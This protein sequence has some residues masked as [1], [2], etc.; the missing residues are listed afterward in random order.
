MSSKNIYIQT[1]IEQLE[2][3][4]KN[5][6]Y[7]LFSAKSSKINPALNGNL[8]HHKEFVEFINQSINFTEPFVSFQEKIRYY[9]LDKK[10]QH[11]CI[12]C[13]S[14]IN[15]QKVTCSKKCKIEWYSINPKVKES[16][17][18][19]VYIS[20]N[21]FVDGKSLKEIAI[22][23]AKET[24]S[25]KTYIVPESRIQKQKET[26]LQIDPET[27]LTKRQLSGIKRSQNYTDEQKNKLSQFAIQYNEEIVYCLISTREEWS[28]GKLKSVVLAEYL[29]NTIDEKTGKTLMV[30]KNEKGG[31]TKRKGKELLDLQEYRRIVNIHTKNQLKIFGHLLPNIEFRS[32]HNKTNN[33]YHVDHK[34][35]V[36][37]GFN[38]GILPC[39]I[40]SICNLEVIPWKENLSKSSKCSMTIDELVNIFYSEITKSSNESPSEIDFS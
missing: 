11:C 21:T 25:T 35:S 19:A 38:N 29:S 18:K 16:L 34:V 32:N 23:K 30:L 7:S 8:R 31:K 33:A 40:G 5:S 10:E 4:L 20:K 1:K 39:I 22:C 13:N 17:Q 26:M 37:E 27:G 12:I 9:L 14:P 2:L 6:K 15:I 3:I 24:R 28:R 36:L